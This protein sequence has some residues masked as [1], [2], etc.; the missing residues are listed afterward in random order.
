MDG[1]PSGILTAEIMNWTGR[2]VSGSRSDLNEILG[3]GEANSPGV[4]F[5][6]G[7]NP[8]DPDRRSVYVGEADDVA[9]RLRQHNSASTGKEFWNRVI[10]LTSKDANLT[11]AH[12][13]YL[14]SRFISLAIEANRSSLENG[15]ESS[16]ISL[17]EADLSDMEYFISQAQIVLP[18]LGLDAFRRRPTPT[19]SVGALGS[20][21]SSPVFEMK[22]PTAGGLARAQ[23]ID[24]EFVVAAGSQARS[25]WTGVGHSYGGLYERLFSMGVL[26]IQDG[27]CVFADDYAFASPSAAAAIVAGRAANG[28]TSWRDPVSGQTFAQWQEQ[29]APPLADE[30]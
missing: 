14:E 4:Y 9:V 30:A 19:Q 18:V 29:L 17:P 11:K 6:L 26:K 12:V 27:G 7:D 24:G 22:V 25:K 13:R 15:N 5:L 8:E 20:K 3:R 23:D 1:A 2:V 10:F 16:K 21:Y 28:R